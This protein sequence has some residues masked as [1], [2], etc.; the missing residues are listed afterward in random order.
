MNT[1]FFSLLFNLL[2]YSYEEIPELADGNNGYVYPHDNN[3]RTGYDIT[4]VM[5]ISL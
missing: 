3:K 1:F 4:Y 5:L 2:I